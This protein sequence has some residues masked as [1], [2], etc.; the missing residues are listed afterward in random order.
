MYKAV[1]LTLSQGYYPFIYKSIVCWFIVVILL[2]SWL[3]LDEIVS[4]CAFHVFQNA[5]F[6]QCVHIVY[7]LKSCISGSF[8]YYLLFNAIPQLFMNIL[9]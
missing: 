6:K 7:F 3:K 1:S 9:K 8:T 4:E 2:Q 5:V